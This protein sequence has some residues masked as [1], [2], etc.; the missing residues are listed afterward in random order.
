MFGFGLLKSRRRERLRRK[1]FP[2]AWETILARNFA[3][4]RKLTPEERTELRGSMQIFLAEKHFE[5]CGG[6]VLTDEVRVTIAAEACLLLLH[7]ETD[8]YPGLDSILVYPSAYVAHERRDLGGGTV[9]EGDQ[10]REG[11]SWERGALVLAWDDALRGARELSGGHNLSLHE[12]AHQLDQEDGVADGAPALERSMYATWA[13]VLGREYSQ[14]LHDL[15]THHHN[16]IDVYGATN[17]AEFFAVVTETFF[18]RPKK[19]RAT[20]PELYDEL[21]LFYRQDPAERRE[22]PLGGAG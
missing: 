14:L 22:T 9:A 12:F 10:A 1:P 4:D 18:E 7:R 21:Q 5:G 6:F 15:K 13:A 17:P 16:L 3:Y 19:L 2:P 8:D 11:E 20:H